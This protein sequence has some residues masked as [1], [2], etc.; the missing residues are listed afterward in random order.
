MVYLPYTIIYILPF[1]NL[2]FMGKYTSP[3][4]PIWVLLHIIPFFHD[5]DTFE[6]L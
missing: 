5:V 2:P 1:K 3:M 6:Y 4:D